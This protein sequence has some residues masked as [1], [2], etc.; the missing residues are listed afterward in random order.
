MVRQLLTESILLAGAGSVLG[1]LLA[2]WGTHILVVLITDPSRPIEIALSVDR[3]VL[4]FTVLLSA[5]TVILFGLA[6]ALRATRVDLT[7]GLK[8][9]ASG[10]VG[11]S[12]AKFGVRKI[13]VVVQTAI[14]VVLLVGAGLFVRTLVKLKGQDLGF[15]AANVLTFRLDPQ[16]H[17]YAGPRILAFYKGVLDRIQALPGVQSVSV[18]SHRLM[19]NSASITT[20]VSAEGTPPDATKKVA[21]WLNAVSSDFLQTMQIKIVLGRGIEPQDAPDSPRVAVINQVFARRFFGELNPIGRWI[22]FEGLP[23]KPPERIAVVGVSADAKYADIHEPPPPTVYLS[24]QQGGRSLLGMDFEVRAFSNPAALAN[25]VRQIVQDADKD[26]PL[27]NVLTQTEQ[28]DASLLQ[29]RM[30][31]KL[32]SFFGG[33]SLLLACIGLYGVMAYAVVQRTHEIGI[34]K[35]LGA[36]AG[37]VLRMILRESLLLVAA[38][39]ALGLLAAYFSTRLIA[40]FL[41]QLKPNDPVALGSAVAALVMVACV[42]AFLPARRAARVDPMIALRYE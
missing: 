21:V 18:S 37:S 3:A 24:F 31:A 17:G 7:S 4:L 20:D 6:P 23:G 5:A 14:S 22:S 10:A 35:A 1:L 9:N 32:V 30:F 19:A 41:F 8:E 34:R 33:L 40:S 25:A 42:A 12:G 39:A 11:Q 28:I 26:I 16:I 29:E 15:N 13:L 38:G 2:A 27:E 36:Q